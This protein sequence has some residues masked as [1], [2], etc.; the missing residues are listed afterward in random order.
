MNKVEHR[1]IVETCLTLFAQANLLETTMYLRNRMH[2]SVQ[3]NVSLYFCLFKKQPNYNLL[4]F[5]GCLCF[6]Y[7]RTYNNI[8]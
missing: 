6:V 3:N 2:T 1:R 4:K 7:F 8:R 5:F